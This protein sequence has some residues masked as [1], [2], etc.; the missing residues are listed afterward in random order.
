MKQVFIVGLG[1]IGASLATC[2]KKTQTN[3]QIIGWDYS[4]TTCELALERGIIQEKAVDF[5]TGAKNCDVLVFATP[6]AVTLDYFSQLAQLDYKKNLLITDVGSTKL[7]L[8]QAA[9][10][11][12]LP[13]LGGHP[14]AGSHKSGINACDENLFE[15][16]YYIF[17]PKAEQTAELALLHELFKGTRAKYVELSPKEHDE[18]TG[19]LSHL[20]H[21]IAASLVTQADVFN[22]EHPRAKQ[23]AAGGF[24]DITRIA[25]SDPIMWTDILLSNREV[26][27]SQLTLWQEEMSKVQRLLIHQDRQGITQFFDHAKDTRDRLP[28]HKNGAIPAFYDLFLDIPDVPGVIAEVTTLLGEASISI[29]NLKIQETREDIHGVLQITFKSQRDLEA[30]KACLEAKT[31]YHCRV[32]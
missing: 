27:M 17:T 10:R 21:I 13:F 4:T 30:G 16:A 9:E 1:L 23:L 14:M 25:S 5:A 24:R 2:I 11:L 15:E 7:A 3:W 8:S 20:P 18:I 28:I 22:Q 26:L 12:Q 31:P 6:V 19:M 32:K 29:T